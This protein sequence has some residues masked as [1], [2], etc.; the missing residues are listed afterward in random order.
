M[1]NGTNH[2]VYRPCSIAMLNCQRVI[3]VLDFDGFWLVENLDGFCPFDICFL[4]FGAD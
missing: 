1:L 4:F 2:D 3:S